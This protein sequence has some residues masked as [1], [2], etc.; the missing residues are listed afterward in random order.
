MAMIVGW[1]VGRAI[2]VS[3]TSNSGTEDKS[4]PEHSCSAPSPEKHREFQE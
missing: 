2:G 1:A 3:S 4:Q